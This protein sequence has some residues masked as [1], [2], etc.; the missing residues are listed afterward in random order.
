MSNEEKSK[1]LLDYE[2]E[3]YQMYSDLLSNQ[4]TIEEEFD[5]VE[6]EEYN[7]MIE[8]YDDATSALDDLYMAIKNYRG[9]FE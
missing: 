6:D 8:A 2:N 3:A 1:F 5:D 7:E 9:K 4:S